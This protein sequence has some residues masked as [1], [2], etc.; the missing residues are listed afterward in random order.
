MRLQRATV[1]RQMTNKWVSRKE[2][3]LEGRTVRSQGWLERQLWRARPTR[4]GPLGVPC[5]RGLM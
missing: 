4:I 5:M 2:R 3:V 1:V